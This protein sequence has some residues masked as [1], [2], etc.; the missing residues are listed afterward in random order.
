MPPM[1]SSQPV[2]VSV[3]E[4][5]TVSALRRILYTDPLF[6]FVLAQSTATLLFDVSLCTDTSLKRK[7]AELEKQVESQAQEI[8]V[9]YLKLFHRF[10]VVTTLRPSSPN[11][12]NPQERPHKKQKKSNLLLPQ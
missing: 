3:S 10:D 4:G 8:K 2:W 5:M 7:L 9:K 11:P 6:A 1:A 12:N